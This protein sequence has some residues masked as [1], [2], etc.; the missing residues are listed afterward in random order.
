MN[1]QNI[2]EKSLTLKGLKI[3]IIFYILMVLVNTIM[4]FSYV[5]FDESTYVLYSMIGVLVIILS[6]GG[7]YTGIQ[8]IRSDIK[9]FSPAHKKNVLFAKKLI[10]LGVALLL[11]L[12]FLGFLF[13]NIETIYASIRTIIFLPFWLS[14]IFL[15]KEIS[16][17]KIINLFWIAISLRFVLF[18]LSNYTNLLVTRNFESILVEYYIPINLIAIIPS[19]I[20]IYCY[21]LTYMKIKNKDFSA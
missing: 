20:F 15:I 13:T 11:I 12:N 7:I 5:V 1:N 10:Y 17:K 8:S 14:L 19:I 9:N 16:T 2:E 3:V 18:Y 4:F 6:L 21:Y